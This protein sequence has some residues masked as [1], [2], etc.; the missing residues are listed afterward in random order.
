MNRFLLLF[1]FSFLLLSCKTKK[2]ASSVGEVDNDLK[3]KEI[4]SQHQKSFPEFE[5]LSGHLD[6]TFDNGKNQQSVTLS[7]RMKKNEIIWLSAPLGI[8]KALI[9]PS[10]I[11]F[12]NKLDNSYFDGDFRIAKQFLGT[13]INFEMLQ[14][15]LLGQLLVSPNSIEINPE[16]NNYSG[17]FSKDGLQ[18]QFLLNPKFRVENTQVVENKEN[19]HL[20]AQYQYQ[21]IGEQLM[22][23]FLTLLS[24]S[25]NQE[26]SIELEYNNIQFNTKQ[27]FPY[28]VPSG[29]K[30]LTIE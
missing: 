18:V 3:T 1:L 16:A 29:Y 5:T 21:E 12:Y 9:T 13:E 2:T 10:K 15:L 4:I 25:E 24:K 20:S 8:A 11:Q 6:V 23:S 17:T 19:I 7:L 22:P 28:K 26:T 27:N 30:L 14:N